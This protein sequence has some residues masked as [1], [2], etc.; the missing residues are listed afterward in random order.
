MILSFSF[1]ANAQF[2]KGSLLLGGELSFSG[3]ASNYNGNDQ[4]THQGNFNIS[5][6]KAISENS[7]FGINL[8]Y[9]P[10][11]QSNYYQFYSGPLAYKRNTYGIGIFYRK[12]KTLGNEFYLF[13]E[14]GAGY[15]FSNES[16]TDNLGVK[17]ITGSGNGGQINFIPGIAYKVSQKLFLEIS[18]PYIILASYNN[19]HTDYQNAPS[20]NSKNNSFVISTSLNGNPLSALGFGFRLNL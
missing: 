15:I 6:G 20:Q 7:V 9:S 11:S 16:G 14:A 4:N 19:S 10:Y 1:L 5:L 18:I 17:Q 3:Y 13:G 12:Y 8:T 2:S